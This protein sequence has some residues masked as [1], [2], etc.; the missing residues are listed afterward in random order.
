MKRK[1]PTQFR[2]RFKRWKEGEQVYENGLALPAYKDGL[3]PHKKSEVNTNQATYNPEEDLYTGKYTLPEVTITGDKSKRVYRSHAPRTS[4]MSKNQYKV[5][6]GDLLGAM[7]TG[8]NVLNPS[9]WYG[10]VRDA[11]GLQ[12]GFNRLMRGNSGFVTKNFEREH[13]YVSLAGNIIGDALLTNIASKS[14]DFA[15]ALD[16]GFV[17]SK[18]I[19]DQSE[20][21]MTR[22][23][24]TGDSG[25]KDALVSDVIRGNMTPPTFSANDLAHIRR[26]F[27]KK[28]LESDFRDLASNNIKSEDQFNRINNILR[29]GSETRKL[30]RFSLSKNY[31]LADSWEDYLLQNKERSERIAEQA[32]MDAMSRSPEINSW[33]KN[34]AIST[35]PIYPR[36]HRL[37]TFAL[38]NE[39]LGNGLQFP[40]DYAVQIKNADKYARSATTFGHFAEHPTTYRPMSPFEEDVSMFVRKDGLLTG[41]KYM[42]KIPKKKMAADKM[43]YLQNEGYSANPSLRKGIGIDY[44][45]LM[46][47]NTSNINL[48]NIPIVTSDLINYEIGHQR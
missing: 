47:A 6:T 27:G 15:R 45:K 13:P 41:N 3:T 46:N 43:K 14:A 24:G 16:R 26:R 40:G 30:G 19:L 1:D 22:Y 21:T 37:P 29:A 17:N 32:Y 10:A 48:L 25:Y 44:N 11:E 18:N 23:I 4:G 12:D 31:T 20:N 42:V 5:Q 9:Q 35:D 39:K 28:M 7:T 38:S 36:G 34:W 2:D 33:I 8:M